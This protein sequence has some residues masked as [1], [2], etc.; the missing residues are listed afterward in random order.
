[1]PE[2]RISSKFVDV[3][4]RRNMIQPKV[5]E[6]NWVESYN[7]WAKGRDQ[8]LT[9]LIRVKDEKIVNRLAEIQNKLSAVPCVDPFPKE[10]LHI[11]VKECGFLAESEE[12]EDNILA[13]NT[14]RIIT[15]AQQILQAHSRFEVSLSRLN[16]F[17]DVVFIEVH[18][19]GRIGVIN[20]QLQSIQET[21]RMEYDYPNLLPHISISQFQSR[22]QFNRLIRCLEKLRETEFGELTI[23]YIEL[24]NAH[25]SGKYPTLE[26]VHAFKLK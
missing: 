1:L 3:W 20:K 5:I 17:Q 11:T 7:E 12:Y 19:R 22:Q 25:I 6:K 16:I 21:R 15:Q 23:N 13:M 26:S 24:V 4:N 10:Y 9:F 18:D 8:Y 14:G 2:D